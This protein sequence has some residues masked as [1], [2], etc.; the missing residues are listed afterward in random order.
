MDAVGGQ[1]LLMSVLQP[2][3]IW[4]KTNRW[5]DAVVDNWFKTKLL[6]GTELGVGLTHEE[7]I[8]DAAKAYICIVQR[9]ATKR[10]P[11]REQVPQR[12]T[13]QIRCLA[14]P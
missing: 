2:S 10:V 11:D 6:N 8:V 3:D 12:K 14:W 5:D 4:E 13:R 7:P 9:S 1:E